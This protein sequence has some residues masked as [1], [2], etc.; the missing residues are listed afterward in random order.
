MFISE[1]LQIL[2]QKYYI[3]TIE[4]WDL[5][6]LIAPPV[7]SLEGATVI[8]MQVHL[9]NKQVGIECKLSDVRQ[10]LSDTHARKMS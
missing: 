5:R 2:N 10:T 4:D 3:D 1:E 8:F 7:T 9:E 6:T